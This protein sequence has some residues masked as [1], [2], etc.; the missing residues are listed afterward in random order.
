[1]FIDGGLRVCLTRK[2]LVL[3]RGHLDLAVIL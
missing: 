3:D 1:M 2:S